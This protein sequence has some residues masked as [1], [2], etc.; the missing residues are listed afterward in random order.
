[1]THAA[2]TTTSTSSVLIVSDKHRFRDQLAERLRNQGIEVATV[3]RLAETLSRIKTTPP[4]LI[5]ADDEFLTKDSLEL[6][7]HVQQR[8]QQAGGLLLLLP[9]G[10]SAH[11]DEPLD[12]TAP[13]QDHLAEGI[14]ALLPQGSA[15]APESKERWHAGLHLDQR[16]Q[17]AR[18]DGRILGVTVTEFRLLWALAENPGYVLT[19]DELM[20]AARGADTPSRERT[21]DVHIRSIRKALGDR[22]DLIE[23]V[24][25]VGYRLSE[26]SADDYA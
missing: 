14:V 7:R 19:R 16:R 12:T 23:T 17:Q 15:R 21:I 13:D 18:I 25:G 9:A 20:E 1:M 11:V 2:T 8:M 26:A 5:V 6:C 24:R 22:A 10:E 4:R 3:D